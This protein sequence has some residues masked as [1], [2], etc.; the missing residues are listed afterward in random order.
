MSKRRPQALTRP[1]P[2]E[3][4]DSTGDEA[5]PR[6]GSL[7]RELAR[8]E[9]INL[10]FYEAFEQRDV[11][12][13]ALVWSKSPYARCVHPGW[14]PVVGWP[15]IQA[16]WSEIFES[17]TAIEF[18]LE[19]VHV[20]VSQGSAWVNLVAHAEVTTDEDEAFTT[21]VVASSVFEKTDGEW[22]IVLHH[23]SHFMD[24]EDLDADDIDIGAAGFGG[25][26]DSGPLKPN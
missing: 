14:E 16:S 3:P 2:M 11:P 15:D 8:V 19:D 6:N 20:E 24:D 7:T 5:P 25:R 13:M 10:A 23:S 17:M 9:A 4:S 26:G 22:H 21:S 12:M 1:E 18:Q